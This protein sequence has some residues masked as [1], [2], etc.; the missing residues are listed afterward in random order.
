[1]RTD[2]I[3]R[4]E[5]PN[6]FRRLAQIPPIMQFLIAALVLAPLAGCAENTRLAKN[7]PLM[8]TFVRVELRDAGNRKLAV[9]A[10]D[11][12]INRMRKLA[13]Q[14]DYKSGKCQETADTRKVLNEAARLKEMTEG[15]FDVNFEG[16]S[17]IDLGG[18][19]KGFIVDEGILVLKKHGIR[20]AIINAG[21]DMYCMGKYRIGVRDPG[22]RRKIIAVLLA[23]DKG[24]ATSADYE[25]GAHIIDP[26]KGQAVIKPGKSVTV[27][28]E[29]CMRAD[30]LATALYVM[31]PREGLSLIETITGAECFI[32]DENGKTYVSGGLRL[33]EK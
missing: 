9:G 20:E 15:A 31:E 29:T 21:G 6:E 19:A 5:A 23:R 2:V 11:E 16:G 33:E 4:R 3:A 28:A 17:E 8:D 30:A 32:V 26:R 10:I 25:R 24:I 18:I 14:L 13:A 7:I 27:T 22:R 12:A 1:M